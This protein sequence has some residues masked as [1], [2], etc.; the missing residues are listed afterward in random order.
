VEPRHENR[1]LALCAFLGFAGL[2]AGIGATIVD[3]SQLGLIAGV[4]ALLAGAVAALVD[5][6][7]VRSAASLAAAQAAAR[8][9]R[10]RAE[11]HEATAAEEETISTLATGH[12]PEPELTVATPEDGRAAPMLAEHHLLVLLE[13]ALATARRKMVPLSVVQWELD[14]VE[15]APSNVR[16]EAMA[17]L[18]DVSRRHVR[19]SDAVF[20]VGDAVA[21]AMLAETAEPGAC[22]VARRVR[23]SLRSSPVGGALTV[24]AGIATYP[25]H[26]LVA[27]VLVSRAADALRAA[28]ELGHRRDHIAVARPD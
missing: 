20:Q 12:A 10:R 25:V 16:E 1:A 9:W 13:Q 2:G 17:M 19:E 21:V 27:D 15:A 22:L 28:R 8:H 5:I 26:A 23:E 14:D 7:L 11:L 3:G 4:I 24:S 18:G 6:R